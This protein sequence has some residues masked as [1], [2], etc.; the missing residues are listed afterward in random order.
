[1]DFFLDQKTKDL[2]LDGGDFKIIQ[3]QVDQLT[4][5]L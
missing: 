4:Q 1:M 5:R 2:V 3:N